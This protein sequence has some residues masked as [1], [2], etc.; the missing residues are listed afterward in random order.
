M[1]LKDYFDR[2]PNLEFEVEATTGG[3]LSRINTFSPTPGGNGLLA[4]VDGSYLDGDE[5]VVCHYEAGA[6]ST[7][8]EA[9]YNLHTGVATTTTPTEDVVNVNA[10][11]SPG[12]IPSYN[13][14][15]AF[16]VENGAG[17]VDV[18][19]WYIAGV[20]Q[21]EQV[22][23]PVGADEYYAAGGRSWAHGNFLYAPGGPTA[24]GVG[25]IGKW[26]FLDDGH[27]SLSGTPETEYTD[28]DAEIGSHVAGADVSITV[29]D[30]G[31]LYAV[32][33]VGSDGHLLKIDTSDMSVVDH[34]IEVS[35]S[36]LAEGLVNGSNGATVTVF[37]GTLCVADDTSAKLYTIPATDATPLTL[38][39]NVSVTTA[40]ATGGFKP[41]LS[42]GGG[43]VLTY[44]GVLYLGGLDTLGAC[45][46]AICEY[47]GVTVSVDVSDLTEKLRGFRIADQMTKQNAI[48]ELRHAFFFGSAEVDDT[49]LFRHTYHDPDDDIPEEDLAAYA[50]GSEPPSD[51]HW[52]DTPDDEIPQKLTVKFI[53]A[54]SDYQGNTAVAT[55]DSG[56]ST[57]ETSLDLA[58]V[59]TY[60][61]AKAIADTHMMREDV[62]RWKATFVVPRKWLT[63]APLDIY[64]VGE[65]SFR[66]AETKWALGGNVEVSA[67]LARPAVFDGLTFGGAVGGGVG[68][69]AGGGGGTTRRNLAPTESVLMDIAGDGTDPPY[70]FAWAAGPKNSG[71]WP[72]AVLF[73]S[74]DGGTTYT[75]V[76]RKTTPD[77][78][79]RSLDTLGTYAG[80]IATP[81]TVSTVQL[82]L[83][84]TDATLSTVTDI[85]LAGGANTAALR[86]G[87]SWEIL[88]GR[89]AVLASPQT[90]DIDHFLRG[91]RSTEAEIPGHAD[92]DTFVGLPVSF[93]DAPESDLD[94]AIYYQAVTIGQSISP[95]G[96]VLFTNTGKN[97]PPTIG[98]GSTHIPTHVV[99]HTGTTYTF[100][101]GDR[102]KLHVFNNAATCTVTLP[103]SGL[104]EG[105]WV[106]VQNIGVGDVVLDPAGSAEVDE[107][108]TSVTLGT[109]QGVFLAFKDATD[110]YYTERG[111]GGGG[112]GSPYVV[113]TQAYAGSTTIDLT[114]LSAYSHVRVNLGALTGAVAFNI[115]NGA[116]AQIIRVRFL[117]DGT[118]GRLVT[119]GANISGSTD[120]PL[121]TLSTAANAIDFFAFEWDAT[122]GKARFVAMVRGFA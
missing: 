20:P 10:T 103:A 94:V 46:Q 32:V 69:G 19:R 96:W 90:Y 28:L 83:T 87:S 119:W 11:V 26:A 70:G 80:P 89:D 64:T 86:S 45:V 59:F 111:M 34:W 36:L 14:N 116:D 66:V 98:D 27:T 97:V 53:D 65:Q 8:T 101:E 110:Y 113:I 3:T 85:A 92:G 78:I 120:L 49:I 72:G 55:R 35:P 31:Y 38:I 37:L 68:G 73:K 39:P 5:I 47:G 22:L 6:V 58:I 60:A 15:V 76:A 91:Q 109:D 88:Q 43:Y 18:S 2:I 17:T 62:E 50:D 56:R 40:A 52:V 74:Y 81:D 107:S 33:P 105:W 121:S 122:S 7:Y 4:P 102:T 21:L 25:Y 77:I 1:P 115:T 71:R 23:P 51:I 118:G 63:I 95:T 67:L 84:R 114:G 112:G 82:R 44:D 29:G 57:A 108:A 79:G 16:G 117:Q 104:K 12:Y 42:L 99:L 93:V 100:V 54:D 75:E 24:I 9:R 41:M 106:R 61:E 13:S 30:D 48:E